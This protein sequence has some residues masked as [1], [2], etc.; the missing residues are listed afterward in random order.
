[1]QNGI[2]EAQDAIQNNNAQVARFQSMA[3]HYSTQVNEDVQAYTSQLQS[4]I[5]TMQG[6]VATEQNK[7]TKYQA[8]LGE[9]QAEVAAETSEYQNKIQ[10][11]QVYSKESDKY[12]QWANAEIQMYIQNNSKM[13]N[14]TIA[15][16]AS[17]QQQR[18]R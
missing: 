4:D 2:Q 12:Y 16:Q 10:K 15:A 5:Q 3:Q 11:Q 9:Y 1:M 18:S 7:L 13:I 8:E 6:N 14:R 17:T